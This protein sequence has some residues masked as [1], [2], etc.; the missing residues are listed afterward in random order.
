[1]ETVLGHASWPVIGSL[2]LVPGVFCRSLVDPK[3]RV[4]LVGRG[5]ILF[6]NS[7]F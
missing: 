4:F 7:P 6:M 3:I 2:L 1:M 5:N